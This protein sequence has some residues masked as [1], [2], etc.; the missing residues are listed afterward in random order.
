ML[1]TSLGSTYLQHS[2]GNG[3]YDSHKI[4]NVNIIYENDY[5]QLHTAKI[6]LTRQISQQMLNW[7]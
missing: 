2:T 6:K 7:Q 3:T 1:F 4:T 5:V